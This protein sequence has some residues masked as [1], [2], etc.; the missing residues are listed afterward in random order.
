M[1]AARTIPVSSDV[2][3]EGNDCHKHEADDGRG[4]LGSGLTGREPANKAAGRSNVRDP[5]P[6]PVGD[7]DALANQKLFC[8]AG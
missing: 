6:L 2:H 4:R 3:T 1:P 5:R 7:V 8:E